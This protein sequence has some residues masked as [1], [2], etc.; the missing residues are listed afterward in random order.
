[1]NGNKEGCLSKLCLRCWSARVLAFVAG[2]ALFYLGLLPAQ[3]ADQTVSVVAKPVHTL[4]FFPEYRASANV[5]ALNESRLSAQITAVVRDIPVKVGEEVKKGAVLV[6]LDCHDY[7]LVLQR[8]QAQA[9]QDL[10]EYQFQRAKKLTSQ[11]AV[12]EELLK[13]RETD[14]A[15]LQAEARSQQAAIRQAKRN[16]DN[17]VLRAPY[18]AIVLERLGQVGELASPV[19]PLLRILDAQQREVSAKLQEQQVDSIRDANQI[20]LEVRGE[21]YPLKLRAITPSIDSRERTQEV[22]LEFTGQKAL[23]GSAGDIVWRGRQSHLP[24]EL[25]VR[26]NNRLGLF[27]VE[28]TQGKTIARFHVVKAAVEGRPVP[29]DLPTDALVVTQG[30]FRLQPGDAVS[31]H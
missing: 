15:V 30:R 20:T 3:A 26:R 17:C 7:E 10:A 8:E 21:S 5:E 29:S 28:K 12:A 31:L 22:R 23:P 24:A 9:K 18:D 16:V 14:L 2:L 13:Q 6:Q 25:L 19:S 27:V 11:Q 4:A 1:M